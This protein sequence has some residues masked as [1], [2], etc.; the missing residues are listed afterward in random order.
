MNWGSEPITIVCFKWSRPPSCTLPR[1]CDYNA[2]HVGC[3]YRGLK[4]HMSRPF[5][6]VCVSDNHSGMMPEII[7]VP[8]WDKCLDMGKCYNRMYVFT[9]A[10]ARKIGADRFVCMDLDCVVLQD[11]WPLFDRPEDFVMNSYNPLANFAAPDQFYNGSMFMMEAG[12]REHV[13][14]SFHREHT[15]RIIAANPDLCIGSDQAWIRLVLGKREA[16]WTRKDGVLEYR[17]A[18]KR[19]PDDARLVFFSGRR[20]PSLINKSWVVENWK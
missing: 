19:L 4:R 5:R 3:L 12:A 17:D 7:K 1:V 8:L 6:F 9:K 11:L 14:E 20:D 10:A 15:P 13:W 18:A 2:R 16:R